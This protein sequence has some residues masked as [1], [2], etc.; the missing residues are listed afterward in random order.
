MQIK[1]PA[2]GAGAVLGAILFVGTTAATPSRGLS[3]NVHGHVPMDG[4][5]VPSQFVRIESG[6]PYVV[7]LGKV[8][9]LTSLGP[10]ASTS[11]VRLRLN[12]I[13]EVTAGVQQVDGLAVVDVPVG[14]SA[15]AGAA[16]EVTGPTGMA[17][18]FL[19]DE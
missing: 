7:P 18:G 15:P 13:P 10:T 16:L 6:M 14:F 5:P 9:V 3:V 1:G 12:G 17:T 4:I 2:F 11:M 19:E 8:F